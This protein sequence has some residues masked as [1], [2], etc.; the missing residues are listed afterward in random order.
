M[1]EGGS[2]PRCKS[3]WQSLGLW[4][5]TTWGEE[6]GPEMKIN[7]AA[8]ESLFQLSG[9]VSLSHGEGRIFQQSHNEP[10]VEPGSECRPLAI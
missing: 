5:P 2:T 4:T 6:L 10:E 7:P 8:R 1:E 9:T 3:V